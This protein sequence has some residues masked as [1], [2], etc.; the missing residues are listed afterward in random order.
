M[1]MIEYAPRSLPLADIQRFAAIAEIP[2]E[3]VDSFGQSLAGLVDLTLKDYEWEQRA[4]RSRPTTHAQLERIKEASAA[5][6]VELDRL[7]AGSRK[8]LCL[9]ALWQEQCAPESPLANANGRFQIMDI[10]EAGGMEQGLSRIEFY[11]E[12]INSLHLAAS[13]EEWPSNPQGGAPSKSFGPPGNPKVSAYDHF[14]ALLTREVLRCG[15][16][17]TVS[18]SEAQGYGTL[19]RLLDATRDYF[20]NGFIPSFCPTAE[21]TVK[22][23][24]RLKELRSVAKGR[25]NAI[26]AHLGKL[27]KNP[28]ENF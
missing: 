23:L 1:E 4:A 8:H 13:T 14:V 2:G 28:N 12:V 6:L 3:N 5:L 9:Y 7:N 17:T 24:R 21:G 16:R 22:G 20:P 18:Q 15:G 10:V 19:P 25:A 26:P 11:R 27:D